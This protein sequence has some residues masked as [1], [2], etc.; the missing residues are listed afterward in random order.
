MLATSAGSAQQH[1]VQTCYSALQCIAQ[2]HTCNDLALHVAAWIAGRHGASQFQKCART[3][4]VAYAALLSEGALPL[5]VDD[6]GQQLVTNAKQRHARASYTAGIKQ[7]TSFTLESSESAKFEGLTDMERRRQ[8]RLRLGPRSISMMSSVMSASSRNSNYR[9]PSARRLD[10]NDT[11]HTAGPSPA[12][13]SNLSLHQANPD[14]SQAHPEAAYTSAPS[15]HMPAASEPSSSQVPWTPESLQSMFA[16]VAHQVTTA[17]D[18]LD[19]S[20]Q[21]LLQGYQR[22]LSCT[23]LAAAHAGAQAAETA[24]FPTTTCDDDIP[25]SHQQLA[26][27][28]CHEAELHGTA[29]AGCSSAQQLLPSFKQSSCTDGYHVLHQQQHEGSNTNV[30]QYISA[31]T[32]VKQ[33]VNPVTQE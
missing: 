3:A 17:H 23:A 31:G 6:Q 22:F 30:Q 14:L 12:A 18:V 29:E 4:P 20:N 1:I 15:Q 5:G 21:A 10:A 19:C 16:G 26:A 24:A 11:T 13:T 32:V 25:C 2:L 7:D 8:L 27:G 33:V 28:S 9:A